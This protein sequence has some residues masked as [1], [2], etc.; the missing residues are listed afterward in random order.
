MADY[1][2]EDYPNPGIDQAKKSTEF[3]LEHALIAIN[4]IEEDM[5]DCMDWA[6]FGVGGP[7]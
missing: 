1:I 3:T 4:V 5:D 7:A 2:S 6:T